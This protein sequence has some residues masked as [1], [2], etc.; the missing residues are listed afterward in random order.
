[1]DYKIEMKEEAAQPVLAVRFRSSVTELPAQLGRIYG[2]IINYIQGS[3]G[4][5]PLIPYV[6]YFNMDMQD[7]DLERDTRRQTSLLHSQGALRCQ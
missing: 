4:T 2:S 6:A 1:M 7:L 3:G 5:T